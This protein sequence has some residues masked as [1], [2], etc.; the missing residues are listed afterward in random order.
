MSDGV[1]LYLRIHM[2]MTSD[3]GEGGEKEHWS[4]RVMKK[5]LKLKPEAGLL[6]SQALSSPP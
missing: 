2:L 1:Q 5:I 3:P 6:L 4:L